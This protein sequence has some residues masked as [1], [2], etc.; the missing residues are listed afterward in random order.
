MI[1]KKVGVFFQILWP[2]HKIW[3]LIPKKP[4]SHCSIKKP[5]QVNKIRD[6]PTAFDLWIWFSIVEHRFY[7]PQKI[8]SGSG[9]HD[10]DDGST[11][12]ERCTPPLI[13][14]IMISVSNGFVALTKRN[15]KL[16]SKVFWYIYIL[17]VN[18][19]S[20][21]CFIH[22]IFRFWFLV[23]F[24]DEV[25]KIWKYYVIFVYILQ[26]KMGKM[27]KTERKSCN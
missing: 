6:I 2:S 26:G 27:E 20:F 7:C 15:Y 23:T 19:Y 9:H 13:K 17:I 21:I 22:P 16:K 5:T 3:T 4:P 10:N 14:P 1:S 24:G 18:K 25:T 11:F 12:H 8:L